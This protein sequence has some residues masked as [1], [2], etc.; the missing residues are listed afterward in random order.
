[1]GNCNVPWCWIL[2]PGLALFSSLFLTEIPCGTVEF[3]LMYILLFP[4]LNARLWS[5][6]SCILVKEFTEGGM[7]VTESPQ[8]LQHGT[9]LPLFL[10]SQEENRLMKLKRRSAHLL[11]PVLMSR[12]V[13]HL[14]S[15]IHCHSMIIRSYI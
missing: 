10:A 7:V 6:I 15:S 9:K 3:H 12:L 8:L 13:V 5:L 14:I 1:M 11:F 4:N 2:R